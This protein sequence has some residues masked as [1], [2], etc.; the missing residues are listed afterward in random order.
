MSNLHHLRA[1]VLGLAVSLA[2]SAALAQGGISQ[3][4]LTKIKKDNAQN[5]SDRILSNAM[6]RYNI[7][8]LALRAN[9]PASRDVWFSNEVPSKGISD[10]KQSGRCWLF[11]G[12]N[13]MRAKMI[14]NY[15]LG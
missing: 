1:A 9:N 11:S 14:K 8:D 12:L 10:Q 2:A 3:S 6:A 5:A 4:M 7:N 15:S 13:V